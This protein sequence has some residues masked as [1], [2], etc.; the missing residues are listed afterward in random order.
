METF[1]AA[2]ETGIYA[3]VE[4][5]L[6]RLGSLRIDPP[7]KSRT[8]YFDTFDGRLYRGGLTLSLTDVGRLRLESLA[9]A[10]T[11]EAESDNAPDFVDQLPPGPIRKRLDGIVSVRRLLPIVEVES[12]VDR[13]HL[14]NRDR[15]TVVRLCR[16]QR[17]VR[18]LDEPFGPL[19]QRF[20]LR[21]LRGYDAEAAELRAALMALE[22]LTVD[23]QGT[24]RSA[25]T[26][27]DHDPAG[28]RSKLTTQLKSGEPADA[29][30]RRLLDELQQIM[31]RNESGI[32]DDLDI[33][34]LHDFRVAVR[35]SRSCIGQMR[36]ALDAAALEPFK[37]DLAWLGKI[38]G[39]TRDLD[40][41][42]IDIQHYQRRLDEGD[43]IQ[44]Q[45]LAAQLRQERASAWRQLLKAMRSPRY[46][47]FFERWERFLSQ[48]QA[49][50]EGATAIETL[51]ARRIE[52]RAKK[53]IKRGR[54]LDADRETEALH[55]LR[56]E[57]KKLR[58]LL[59]FFGA[60]LPLG[61]SETLIRGLKRLQDVL[62]SFND[63]CVQQEMLRRSVDPASGGVALS[64]Q[65]C[66]V[67]GRLIEQ[68]AIEE[69]AAR[70]RYAKAFDQFAR[71]WERGA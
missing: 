68:L 20:E 26:A 1:R 67:V 6:A 49:G 64:P 41:F 65:S 21:P 44:L 5:T 71:S 31:R 28:F 14:L 39:P 47:Q 7:T 33:E 30:V 61:N 51:A 53:M 13:I 37:K 45:P 8:T 12:T 58:Y 27:I 24:Y 43:S 55:Q 60:L 11:I 25:C 3:L 42:L 38:S 22:P 4:S 29:A 69:R 23:D 18:S 59:E 34:F 19:E 62:G 70:K 54:R 63:L 40:V 46:R 57:A 32:R 2:N 52:R 17:R 9:G 36:G 10:E 35:R 50:D 15:K 16:I 56:I 48:P 66:L